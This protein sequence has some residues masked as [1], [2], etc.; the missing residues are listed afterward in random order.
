MSDVS[1]ECHYASKKCV[2]VGG[3]SGLNLKVYEGGIIEVCNGSGQ[4]VIAISVLVISN[5]PNSISLGFAI[6]MIRGFPLNSAENAMLNDAVR[7][8]Y[9]AL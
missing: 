5:N 8:A 2:W 3:H 9:R 1:S 7:A 6:D 4:L